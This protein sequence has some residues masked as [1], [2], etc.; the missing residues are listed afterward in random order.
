MKHKKA[1]H[2]STARILQ[3]MEFCK[4]PVTR[5]VYRSIVGNRIDRLELHRLRE[6]KKKGNQHLE[7]QK[8]V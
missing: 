2:T 5:S 6:L 4:N 8:R 7:D 1:F 3:K